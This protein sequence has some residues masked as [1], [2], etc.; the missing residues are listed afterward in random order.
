MIYISS[1]L[2][3]Q[4]WLLL[5]VPACTSGNCVSHPLHCG[6][7]W[8]RDEARPCTETGLQDDTHVL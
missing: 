4:V 2:W 7:W 3:L 8:Y 1:V 6:Q 5:S